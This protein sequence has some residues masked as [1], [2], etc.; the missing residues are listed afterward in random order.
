MRLLLLHDQAVNISY[1]ARNVRG[2]P[3]FFQSLLI[4][5]TVVH[6]KV[7]WQNPKLK[8][9]NL[10]P[11]YS[12]VLPSACQLTRHLSTMYCKFDNKQTSNSKNS[13]S[14]KAERVLG[15]AYLSLRY[16]GLVLRTL[17]R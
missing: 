13:S 6:R 3:D 10:K 2:F 12:H 7:H 14:S 17:Q 1:Q 9:S 15:C 5:F 8:S 4:N 11:A 16:D